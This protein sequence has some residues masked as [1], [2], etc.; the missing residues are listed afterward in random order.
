LILKPSWKLRGEL[1][2]GGVLFSQRKTFETG[3][4]NFKTWKCFLKSYPYTIDYLL[5]D[6]EKIFQNNLQKQ[7]K[8]CKRGPKC[9][10]KRKQ[11]CISSKS[12][13]WFNSKQP[14]HLPYAN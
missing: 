6:F 9:Q 7:N 5:K 11:P 4:E 13:N 2:S 10:N 1:N 12:I 14:M 3:G 8:W